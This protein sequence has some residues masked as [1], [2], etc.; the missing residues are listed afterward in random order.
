MGKRAFLVLG[1]ESAGNRLV[2]RC[3]I[4]AGCE[5]DG[6]HE[7]RF[8]EP[9]GLVGAADLIVI[10]R[11]MPHGDAWPHL[12]GLLDRLKSHGYHDVRVLAMIRTHYCMIRSQVIAGHHCNVS[13][14]KWFAEAEDEVASAMRRIGQFAF[15][16]KLPIRYITFESVI[17][18]FEALRRTL[19]EWGIDLPAPPEALRDENMKY[20]RLDSLRTSPPVA[21]NAT[22]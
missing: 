3:L 6:D 11:S 16:N 19:A 7:Q 18:N 20:L 17:H 22:S 1:P 4:S 14:D 12:D 13:P 9:D 8:D 2:T 5:G 15:E 10:R 21:A